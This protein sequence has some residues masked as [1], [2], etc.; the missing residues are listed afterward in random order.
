MPFALMGIP[1]AFVIGAVG[2]AARSAPAGRHA[3]VLRH[4]LGWGS[5]LSAIG[6][7][8]MLLTAWATYGDQYYD[9]LEWA[10]IFLASVM[11][12]VLFLFGLGPFVPWL[13]G[14]LGRSA[15][16]LPPPVRLAARDLAG[17]RARTAP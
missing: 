6:L 1:A 11:G 16:R 3:R 15:V 5:V 7:A 4:H 8:V 10:G 14:L 9:D 17:N 12:G 13:L 2:F